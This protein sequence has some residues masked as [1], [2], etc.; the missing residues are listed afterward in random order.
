MRLTR[1]LFLGLLLVFPVLFQVHDVKAVGSPLIV[2]WGGSRLEEVSKA[3]P[4]NPASLVFASEQASNQEMQVRRLASTGYNALRVS[5]ESQCTTRKEA[6][7]Y[8][9]TNLERS[10]RIAEHFHFWIIVDY[11]GYN[12]TATTATTACWLNFWTGLIQQFKTRYYQTVWEPLN[13]PTGFG[14]DHNAVSYLSSV[15]QKWIN[16][17][18][19]LGDMNWVVVQSLCS[20]RCDFNDRQ[21]GYPTVTD[22]GGKILISIHT[23][24]SYQYFWRTWDNATAETRAYAF[25][26]IM[27]NGTRITGWASLNTEGGA[28]GT[29]NGTS[30]CPDLV[31]IGSAGYCKTNFHFIQTLT[32]LLDINRGN[33]VNWLWWTVSSTTDTPGTGLYGALNTWGEILRHRT[34]LPGDT[35]SDCKVNILD[36]SQIAYL[37]GKKAGDPGFN[38]AA[39]LNNDGSIDILD[40]SIIAYHYNQT[41]G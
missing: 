24:M 41:C 35:N 29:Y 34:V 20:F 16:Q 23:Y 30:R 38:P 36:A 22:P 37:Y 4:T 27:K 40:L 2:G 5:F 26:N 3:S 21:N 18:R 11:H 39:D 31:T 1:V 33:R 9:A 6:G 14:Y 13:E 12:D 19:G 7:P 28:F 25:Y 8:N 10:F 17:A 32:N 15:Y